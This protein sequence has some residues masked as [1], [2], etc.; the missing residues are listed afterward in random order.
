MS[1]KAYR[2]VGGSCARFSVMEDTKEYT[3]H[4]IRKDF[5]DELIHLYKVTLG[6]CSVHFVLSE[7]VSSAIGLP[8]VDGDLLSSKPL[9]WNFGVY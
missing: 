6:D 9:F 1:D 3:L 4:L 8:F 5:D 7:D 2:D